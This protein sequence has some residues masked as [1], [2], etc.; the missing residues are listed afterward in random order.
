MKRNNP[1]IATKSGL[2]PGGLSLNT[3]LFTT[4]L[5]G[6]IR[7]SLL[8][9]RPAPEEQIPPRVLDSYAVCFLFWRAD[10]TDSATKNNGRQRK[11]THYGGLTSR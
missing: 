2:S 1:A 11:A 5:S 3:S 7:P 4:D 6:L 10:I 8:S 9:L